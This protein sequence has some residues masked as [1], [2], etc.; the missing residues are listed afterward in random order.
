M[1]HPQRPTLSQCAV[2]HMSSQ[3]PT[4]ITLYDTHRTRMP[5]LA[6]RG[7]YHTCIHPRPPRVPVTQ[8]LHVLS[9][10]S[11]VWS[12]EDEEE[13]SPTPRTP[14]CEGTYDAM[15]FTSEAA[16]RTPP[17]G[18]RHMYAVGYVYRVYASTPP[19]THDCT[20]DAFFVQGG[21]LAYT[22]RRC[23]TGRVCTSVSP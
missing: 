21:V 9:R 23:L 3:P 13:G 1:L 8:S 4:I 19:C 11:F 5:Y 12:A 2:H 15:G 22:I 6:E 16:I 20:K 10:L 14:V 17:C 18:V 7:V